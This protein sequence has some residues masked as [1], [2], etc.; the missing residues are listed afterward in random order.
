MQVVGIDLGTTNLRI[1]TWDSEQPDQDPQP[2]TIGQAGGYIMPTVI[3]FRR[4]PGGDIETIVGEAADNMEDVSDHVVVVRNLKRYALAHDPYVCWHLKGWESEWPHWW[5]QDSRC[6]QVWGQDYPVKDL[7]SL[8]LKEAFQRAG[9]SLGFEWRAGCPVH[10]GFTYRS[11]LAE[12]ITELG[13]TG[14]GEVSRVIEESLLLLALAYEMGTLDPGSYLVYDLGGGS[15]DCAL[16]QIKETDDAKQMIIFGADGIP[17]TGGSNM[18]R[19]L[20]EDLGYAGPPNLLRL[21]KEQVSPTAEQS[22]PGG[23]TLTWEHYTTAVRKGGFIPKTF[24]SMRDAYTGAKVIWRRNWDDVDF[25]EIEAALE[26]IEKTPNQERDILRRFEKFLDRE[27]LPVGEVFQKN[28]DSGQVKFVWQL[29]WDNMVQDLD[30]IIVSGGPTK[31]SGDLNKP[32]VLI[33]N[34]QRRFGVDRVI[35]ISELLMI[36]DPELT[37][38]SAGACRAATDEY[39]PL[40]VNRLPVRVILEDRQ[41]GAT[42]QYE[43]YEHLASSSRQLFDNPFVSADSVSEHPDDPFSESRYELTVATPEGILLRTTDPDGDVRERQTV[44]KKY[45]HEAENPTINTRLIGSRL[46]LV[47]DRLGRVGVEQDSERIGPKRFMV[48]QNHPWQTEEQG[49]AIRQTLLLARLY[50]KLERARDQETL[51]RNPWGWQEHPG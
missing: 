22:L 37:A 20:T 26:E 7:I 28:R 15:F 5:N 25:A 9:L 44:G 34:L 19:I 11:E 43:P 45:R 35:P 27:E 17:A 49:K 36:P 39:I 38:I 30:G 6:V 24:A 16:A 50:R 31:L 12:V 18:D 14:H 4:Q 13:G 41:T 51:T 3:A 1:A 29:D 40:Y 46:K 10:A 48:I 21:A 23:V 33:E 8:I 42:V 47:I 2:L 32:S